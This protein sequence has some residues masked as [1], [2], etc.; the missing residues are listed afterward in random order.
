MYPFYDGGS[1]VQIHD[2]VTGGEDT[3]LAEFMAQPYNREHYWSHP[4]A[5]EWSLDGSNGHS[6]SFISIMDFAIQHNKPF[7]VPECGSGSS[8]SGTDVA[9]DGS[10]PYWLAK[11]IVG[12]QNSGLKMA[13]V[14]VWD[15]N[16][17]GNYQFSYKSNNKP[18]TLHNWGYYMGPLVNH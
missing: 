17:D 13:F 3:S 15:T 4:A 11:T 8:D 14:N 1:G 12:G 7:A 16:D 9:D 10:F 2:W 6:Q 18:V 5:T